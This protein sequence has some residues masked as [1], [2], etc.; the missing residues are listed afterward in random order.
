MRGTLERTSL[1]GA[2]LPRQDVLPRIDEGVARRTWVEPANEEE[3]GWIR[4]LIEYARERGV[5][6]MSYSDYWARTAATV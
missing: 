3:T 1:S 6:V 2:E 5:E 4:G